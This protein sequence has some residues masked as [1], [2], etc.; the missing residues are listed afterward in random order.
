[1]FQTDLFKEGGP[2]IWLPLPL[3]P[4]PTTAGPELVCR[5]HNWGNLPQIFRHKIR[6]RS[7]RIRTEQE[8]FLLRFLIRIILGNLGE[9]LLPGYVDR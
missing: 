7:I 3:R 6:F 5:G 2:L 4:S 1:M 8:G 9:I